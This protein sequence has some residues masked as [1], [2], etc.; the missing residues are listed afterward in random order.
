MRVLRVHCS[1]RATWDWGGTV[2]VT[3]ND[4][5]LARNDA[6]LHRLRESKSEWETQRAVMEAQ[7]SGFETRLPVPSSPETRAFLTVIVAQGRAIRAL[8]AARSVAAEDLLVARDAVKDFS[9]VSGRRSADALGIRLREVAGTLLEA[10]E[11]AAETLLAA[12]TEAAHVL[13]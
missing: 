8:L 11:E 5:G 9:R 1:R 7:L 3:E 6:W 10:Q 12:Q 2:A 13:Q 4:P